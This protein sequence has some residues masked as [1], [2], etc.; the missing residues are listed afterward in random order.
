NKL[1]TEV[2]PND[3]YFNVVLNGAVTCGLPED[4]CW[5]LFNHMYQL[6]LNKQ[7]KKGVAE[8]WDD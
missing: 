1:S 2:A 6:Q 3:W 7:E 8:Y 5:S 4:Y